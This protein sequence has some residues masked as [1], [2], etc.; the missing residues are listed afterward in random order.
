MCSERNSFDS[1]FAYFFLLFFTAS[2]G[3]ARIR[4]NCFFHE[5]R[6]AWKTPTKR[7]TGKKIWAN[8]R[9]SLHFFHFFFARPLSW[10]TECLQKNKHKYMLTNWWSVEIVRIF[11]DWRREDFSISNRV[12]LHLL[13]FCCSDCCLHRYRLSCVFLPQPL[14]AVN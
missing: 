11:I 2:I 6:F 7:F 5:W 4:F 9:F 3:F 1:S 10:K 13:S 8:S 14:V 12:P